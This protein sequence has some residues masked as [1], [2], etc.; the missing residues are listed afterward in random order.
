M[1]TFFLILVVG[2]VGSLSYSC[3]KGEILTPEQHNSQEQD[4]TNVVTEDWKNDT[5]QTI[6]VEDF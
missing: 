3:D 2:L 4:T 5:T 1:K 6:I